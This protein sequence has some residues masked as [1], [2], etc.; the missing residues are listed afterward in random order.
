MNPAN[1]ISRHP[2][3]DQPL[4]EC[5]IAEEYVVLTTSAVPVAM[6]LAEIQHATLGDPTLQQLAELIRS[7]QWHSVLNNDS[8]SNDAKSIDLQDLKAFHKVRHVLTVTTNNDTILRG[9]RIMMPAS[10]RHRALQLAQEGHQGL[11]KT[12]QLLREKIWFP[13]ID[14]QAETL[15]KHC[16]PCQSGNPENMLEPLKMSALPSGPWHHVAADF[17]GPLPSGQTLMVVIDEYSRFV[18]VETVS[19]TSAA[20]V[21]PKL[22]K[23][24]ATHGIPELLKTDNGPP[25]TS[26]AFKDEILC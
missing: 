16:L 21:I 14:K 3:Q 20:A 17:Y 19:S 2:I 4:R 11:I 12:K 9:S 22:D 8:S 26:H 10:L 1:Y 7:Q 15:V 13:C 23:I 5:N 6:T 18:E 24:F 25:F